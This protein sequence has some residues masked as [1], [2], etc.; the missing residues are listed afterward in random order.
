M[1][2]PIEVGAIV[3]RFRIR[4]GFEPIGGNHS[5]LW[6]AWLMVCA[7]LAAQSAFAASHTVVISGLG[8]EAQYEE[9][10]RANADEIARIAESMAEEPG[11]VVKLTGAEATRD[12]IRRE[13]KS[14]AARAKEDDFVTIV[15]IGHGTYD[16]E[17]YRFNI[18]GRDITGSE[19][20]D[21]LGAIRADE[22]LIVNTTSASGATL[23]Q[24]MRPGR[25]VITATKSGGERTATRF[26]QYWAEALQN[27]N[28][29]ANKDEIVTASE[30][31]EYASRQ[32]AAAFKADV[33]LATEHSRIE[34][35]DTAAELAVGRLG[36]SA[37][38]ATDPEVKALLAQ[39]TALES[40]IEAIK[41]RRGTLSDDEYYNELESVLV[42]FAL[43]QRE[44]D[45]K[46]PTPQV[47]P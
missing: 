33:A 39:R 43:L 22:Q 46:Q 20:R 29:D 21:L 24:W 36:S 5:M 7:P 27:A 47:S 40:D 15:L 1:G 2:D 38:L 14:L 6:R 26:A 23:E 37:V 18:P 8:G 35:G 11:S 44:I 30:A 17:E 3:K 25:V 19:L 16:G 42:K 31:Y 28:A 12:A 9:R 32:V 10:F 4:N 41:S 13:L 34:G 45:A